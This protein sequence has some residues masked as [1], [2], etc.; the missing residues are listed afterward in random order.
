VSV[1]AYDQFV[2]VQRR[3]EERTTRGEAVITYVDAFQIWAAV[4]PLSGRELFAAQQTQSEV[5]TRVRMH[6]RRGI[7][8]LMRVKHITSFQSPNLFDL[9]DVVSVIDDKSRHIELHL[10][11]TRRASE[12]QL[13]AR[14]TIT[15]D[16]DTIT[17]DNG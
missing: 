5:T 12:Q 13:P 4:E 8:E 7:T 14:P 11:C 17:A 16:M 15:A 3:I 2:V 9:Y 6:W 1:G 10:M